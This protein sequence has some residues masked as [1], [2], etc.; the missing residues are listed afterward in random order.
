MSEGFVDLL[1]PGF[2]P[3]M[4]EREHVRLGLRQLE[5]RPVRKIEADGM[6]GALDARDRD[7]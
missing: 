7:Q 1:Y 5:A 2:A 4:Q 6:S 3:R